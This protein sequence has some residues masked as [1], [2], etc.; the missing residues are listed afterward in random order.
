MLICRDGRSESIAHDWRPWHAGDLGSS[1]AAPQVAHAR[2]R[3][4]ER[5]R[6]GPLAVA[7]EVFPSSRAYLEEL[8]EAGGN[9]CYLH[10]TGNSGRLPSGHLSRLGDG[11]PCRMLSLRESGRVEAFCGGLFR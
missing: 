6:V 4:R 9:S 3:D 10:F 1:L 8:S 2:G 11:R 7:C 5:A